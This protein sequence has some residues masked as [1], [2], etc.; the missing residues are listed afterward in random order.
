M[1]THQSNKPNRTT[2]AQEQKLKRS[3]LINNNRVGLYPRIYEA[4]TMS[5]IK[6]FG[7]KLQLIA[8]LPA[9]LIEHDEPAEDETVKYEFKPRKT[10]KAF[11]GRQLERKAKTVELNKDIRKSDKNFAKVMITNAYISSTDI[12]AVLPSASTKPSKNDA[13]TKTKL[14]NNKRNYKAQQEVI[15]SAAADL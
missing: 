10:R 3:N 1:F 4:L 6:T 14:R 11:D 5:Y 8:R 12:S 9:E 2:M 15:A 7:F 13:Y